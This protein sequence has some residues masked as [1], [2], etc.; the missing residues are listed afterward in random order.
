MTMHKIREKDILNIEDYVDWYG[1][2]EVVLMLAEIA[3]EKASHLESAWQDPHSAKVFMRLGRKLDA[4]AAWL[5]KY[6]DEHGRVF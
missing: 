2:A 6:S 4:Y 1:F 5:D 3:Y